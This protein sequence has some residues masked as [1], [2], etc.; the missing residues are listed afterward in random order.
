MASPVRELPPAVPTYALWH[1]VRLTNYSNGH[2][3]VLQISNVKRVGVEPRVGRI[4]LPLAAPASAVNVD[5]TQ[6]Y[7]AVI[8]PNA[9]GP[10]GVVTSHSWQ[11]GDPV[12]TADLAQTL[13]GNVDRGAITTRDTVALNR[14]ALKSP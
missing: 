8:A 12:F 13:N 6:Y 11:F 9:G 3:E 4:G 2:D 14:F 7:Q 5:C 10:A 1:C